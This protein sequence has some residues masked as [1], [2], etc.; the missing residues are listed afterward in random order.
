MSLWGLEKFDKSIGHQ[1]LGQLGH[2]A[3]L[4]ALPAGIAFGLLYPF[5]LTAHVLWLG[6][7]LALLVSG[8]REAYAIA[9]KGAD[10][11]L[12]DRARDIGESVAGSQW[13][14][15]VVWW[16][17]WIIAG[18]ATAAFIALTITVHKL[19]D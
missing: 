12:A 2:Q 19:R 8:A 10:W 1:L 14:S 6:P 18:A 13:V 15:G 11:N 16:P 3:P 5:G 7:L 9:K 17:A 4:G